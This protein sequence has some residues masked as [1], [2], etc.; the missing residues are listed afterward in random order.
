M[1]YS[2]YRK[3]IIFISDLFIVLL[4][5]CILFL[6]MAGSENAIND[7]SKAYILYPHLILLIISWAVTQWLF[8]TYESLW[9]YAQSREYLAMTAGSL[10]G[11]II[12]LLL[13]CLIFK[14]Q[15]F[16]LYFLSVYS[17]SLLGMLLMRICYRQYRIFKKCTGNKKKNSG[18]NYWSRRSRS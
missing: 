3:E 9:R 8:K 13:D 17:I 12:F 6:I 5:S 14:N 16:M 2:K 18:C 1:K 10:V 15:R 7:L 11:Y 4:V